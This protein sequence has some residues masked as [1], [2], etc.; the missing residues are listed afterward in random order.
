MYLLAWG[1]SAACGL[2]YLASLAWQPELFAHLTGGDA[3]EEDRGV[4]LA[5]RALTEVGVVR[6]TLGEVQRDLG[7]VRSSLAEHDTQDKLAQSRIAALEE[8]MAAAPP[9]A[10]PSETP[11]P[12]KTA[13]KPKP[14]KVH[15]AAARV[16]QGAAPPTPP[17]EAAAIETGSIDGPQPITFGAPVVTPSRPPVYGVQ[18]AT[19]ASLDLIRQSWSMLRDRHAAEL[20]ALQP[21]VVSP[22]SPGSGIYRL[23]VG[24]L[25]TRAEADRVCAALAVGRQGCFATAFVGSPL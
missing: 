20:S 23:L 11:A 14:D 21:H 9:A 25:P 17:R 19:G 6:H 5:N 24:P 4:E 22:R 16:P 1:L 2:A 3:V 10:T 8:R 13:E 7:Q 15:K 12:E 18:L